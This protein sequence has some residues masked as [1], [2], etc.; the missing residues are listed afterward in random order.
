[1]TINIKRFFHTTQISNEL[2]KLSYKKKLVKKVDQ[3]NI[4]KVL[5][6]I[7]S[8]LSSAMKTKKGAFNQSN[9]KKSLRFFLQIIQN[10]KKNHRIQ[11]PKIKEK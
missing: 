11:W 7:I 3:K 2:G 10:K 9:Q 4:K 1:M 6:T 8:N 5:P